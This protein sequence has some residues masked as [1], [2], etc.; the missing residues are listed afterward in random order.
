[1]RERSERHHEE[2]LTTELSKDLFKKNR[3]FVTVDPVDDIERLLEFDTASNL[4][5]G[6]DYS[7]SDASANLTALGEV[8]RWEAAGKIDATVASAILETNPQNFYGL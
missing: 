2:V 7:H 3:L 6:T 1:M 8:K 5:I 4:M